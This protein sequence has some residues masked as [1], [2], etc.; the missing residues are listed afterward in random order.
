MPLQ[1]AKNTKDTSLRRQ[2]PQPQYT[3]LFDISHSYLCSSTINHELTHAHSYTQFYSTSLLFFS[4]PSDDQGT[5]KQSCPI[6]CRNNIRWGLKVLYQTHFTQNVETR[7][8]DIIEDSSKT[9]LRL[10]HLL[11]LLHPFPK[12][13]HRLLQHEPTRTR[14]K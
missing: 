7:R 6:L 12:S 8:S 9:Y 3:N 11:P 5:S 2:Q 10:L 14:L 4:L 1:Q 13:L